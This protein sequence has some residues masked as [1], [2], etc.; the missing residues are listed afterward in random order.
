VPPDYFPTSSEDC[1]TFVDDT[2]WTPLVDGAE[3]FG[4]LDAM[5]QDL[6][7]GDA[8][9]I[10]GLSVDPVIDLHGRRSSDAGYLPL[11]E[12]LARAAVRG[13]LVRV[14]IAGR[15]WASSLPVA[16]LGDFRANVDRARRL[17]AWRPAGSTAAPLADN[18]IVDFAGSL[19][20]SNHQK[21]VVVSK[22][23]V[24]TAFVGGIDLEDNRYD[25]AP[26]DRLKYK[27]ER[28]GWH[29]MVVRLRGPATE[30]VW[31]ILAGR[32]AEAMTL[33]R[34][35]YLRDPLHLV[36]LNPGSFAGPPPEPEP[37]APVAAA[38]TSVRVLRSLAPRKFES[39]LP[40]RSIDW[41]AL[42]HSGYQQVYETLTT[43]IDA[44]QRY[45]YIED[46]YLGE[47][48]GGR[49][50]YELYPQLRAAAA[51]GVKLIF[52]GSGTRDP[53]D[54][55]FH[56]RP[57]NR[58]VNRDL[59]TKI[60]EQ[61]DGAHRADVAVYRI[62]HATVH[63]KLVLIDDAFAC[64]GSANMFSRSM[65]G[66]DNEI[67]AAVQTDTSLVRE[68]RLRV[69]AE[70]LR[71]PLTDDVRAALDDLGLALGIW[72]ERWLPPEAPAVTWR[73][74]GEPVGFAPTETV[75]RRVDE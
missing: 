61:L 46:Q 43:A 54:P 17:Q 73:K 12:L 52:V 26:H 74:R 20:G 47:E 33:P 70:H 25:A 13:A 23:D 6:G 19:P 38:G 10:A 9:L 59:R 40:G 22:G 57:I 5:L 21:V 65:G 71:T 55:G 51:R 75:L 41:D 66:V 7:D 31:R 8:V 24:L 4:A 48:L 45:V 35:R 69:W 11:G 30:R 34:K 36:P 37:Q 44:A 42:P 3:Y 68:L 39:L 29:D 32:W 72:D 28:W 1:P 49:K 64:I 27:G 58:T 56:P 2:E 50:R 53:D 63:A 62:E 14:L 15:V 18:V 67:S 60:I 16:A